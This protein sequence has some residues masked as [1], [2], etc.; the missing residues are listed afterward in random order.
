M[1]RDPFGFHASDMGHDEELIVGEESVEKLQDHHHEEDVVS[2]DYTA[3]RR[4][5]PIHN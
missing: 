3:A 5:P 2:M 4:K 1:R